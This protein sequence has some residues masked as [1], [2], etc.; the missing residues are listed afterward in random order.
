LV[1]MVIIVFIVLRIQSGP[2]TRTAET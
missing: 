1:M 2:L